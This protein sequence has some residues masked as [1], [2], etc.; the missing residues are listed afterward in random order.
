VKPSAYAH[1]D[2]GIAMPQRVSFGSLSVL[3]PAPISRFRSI[4][5]HSPDRP[6]SACRGAD[7]VETSALLRCMTKRDTIVEWLKRSP[8]D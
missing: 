8:F 6:G 7:R 2:I 1:H 5:L 3:T 4:S